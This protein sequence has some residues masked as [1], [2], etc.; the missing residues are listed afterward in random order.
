M[1]TTIFDGVKDLINDSTFTPPIT[2]QNS[3]PEPFALRFKVKAGVTEL[4]LDFSDNT[5]ANV[6]AVDYGLDQPVDY[7]PFSAETKPCGSEVTI[8]FRSKGDSF[9]SGMY[10]YED[11][12]SRFLSQIET[13][14]TPFPRWVHVATGFPLI[15]DSPEFTAPEGLIENIDNFPKF[16][17]PNGGAASTFKTAPK[18]W[19]SLKEFAF[20]PTRAMS[21][22]APFENCPN[23]TK[24]EPQG[25][26][27]EELEYLGPVDFMQ[28]DEN[29]FA[30]PSAYPGGG[31]PRE[32]NNYTIPVAD[33]SFDL[34]Y[35]YPQFDMSRCEVFRNGYKIGRLHIGQNTTSTSATMPVGISFNDAA[36]LDYLSVSLPKI[37][38]E[39]GN[40]TGN[41]YYGAKALGIK[42]PDTVTKAFGIFEIDNL[43][44]EES[45]VPGNNPPLYPNLRSSDQQA[46]QPLT[47]EFAKTKL[48]FGYGAALEKIFPP[49]EEL[50]C[51][52]PPA[53][54]IVVSDYAINKGSSAATTYVSKKTDGSWGFYQVK[55]LPN[56]CEIIGSYCENLY[57]NQTLGTTTF[58]WFGETG[59]QE[60][61]QVTG[62]VIIPALPEASRIVRNN[63]KATIRGARGNA[64]QTHITNPEAAET[65]TYMFYGE[66]ATEYETFTGMTV[67]ANFDPK[68][69]GKIEQEWGRKYGSEGFGEDDG[70]NLM[71][72]FIAQ[73][74]GMLPETYKTNLLSGGIII[75]TGPLP[76]LEYAIN[77]QQ[78]CWLDSTADPATMQTLIVP[79]PDGVKSENAFQRA[80]QFKAPSTDGHLSF[81]SGSTF[82][83]KD[84]GSLAVNE[85]GK[86]RIIHFAT[87]VNP[88]APVDVKQYD[89]YLSDLELPI[90]NLTNTEQLTYSAFSD[91]FGNIY[92]DAD[93]FFTAYGVDN[94]ITTT[95]DR[96]GYLGLE[97]PDYIEMNAM[98]YAELVFTWKSVLWDTPGDFLEGKWL[99]FPVIATEIPRGEK[100]PAQQEAL[101]K[102]KYEYARIN[103]APNSVAIEY[104]L[105]YASNAQVF[106]AASLTW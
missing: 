49:T 45:E 98:P 5:P 70:F 37:V 8:F 21:L 91:M 15:I 90:F 50:I 85:D 41:F 55:P 18:I 86:A 29:G 30:N 84:D 93:A 20:F 12:L 83:R 79:I 78:D 14:H 63:L 3:E 42:V 88:F 22:Y 52:D 94:T 67:V 64:E 66:P 82:G 48:S 68:I 4:F 26:F 75:E 25:E 74:A 10:C 32:V 72:I 106:R 34:G 9:S 40:Y 17:N 60:K 80:L 16:S 27:G 47:A 77:W 71:T 81:Y 57:S 39:S 36:G 97:E 23:V 43:Y 19:A 35:Q 44:V 62:D 46:T 105:T 96:Q 6:T 102:Y 54:L 31:A 33:Y 100:L 7:N 89:L 104:D 2:A 28:Y 13:L 92:G 61:I 87:W 69:D 99:S 56:G 65:K 76:N 103:N 1:K 51:P 11:K 24:I 53:D 95:A 59:E 58:L 101:Y 38:L 73:N